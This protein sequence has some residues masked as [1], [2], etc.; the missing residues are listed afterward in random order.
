MKSSVQ[1]MNL[2]YFHTA[3]D[4]AQVE[5]NSSEYEMLS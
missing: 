2:H 4:Y 1:N 5:C 3:A